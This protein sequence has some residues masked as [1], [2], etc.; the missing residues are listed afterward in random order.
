MQIP[1]T[2]LAVLSGHTKTDGHRL[3]LVGLRMTSALYQRVNEVLEAVGG[4]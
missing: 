4:G 3:M 2:V 1:T